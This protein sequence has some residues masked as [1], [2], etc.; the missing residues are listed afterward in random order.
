MGGT[1]WHFSNIGGD[2]SPSKYM[3]VTP[4]LRP[5]MWRWVIVWVFFCLFFFRVFLSFLSLLLS[6]SQVACRLAVSLVNHSGRVNWVWW[7]EGRSVQSRLLIAEPYR[8]RVATT[9]FTP[10]ERLIFTH[11][12][13]RA[14][15]HLSPACLCTSESH[16]YDISYHE[17][18]ENN[19]YNVT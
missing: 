9:P 18:S 4:W 16:K 14:D 10:M 7:R 2:T 1:D 17:I 13:V 15:N 6:L 19:E 5:Y 11:C 12:A 8:E 3:V